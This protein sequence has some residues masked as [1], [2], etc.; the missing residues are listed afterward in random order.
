MTKNE[1]RDFESQ[2]LSDDD[3]DSVAGGFGFDGLAI[4]T[5]TFPRDNGR[6]AITTDTFPRGQGLP[7]I[8]NLIGKG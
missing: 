6:V 2:E 4:T 5:N 8:G 1:E 3:L 7:N